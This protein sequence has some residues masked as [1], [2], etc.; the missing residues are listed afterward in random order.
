MWGGYARF[1]VILYMGAIVA[2]QFNSVIRV[3]YQRLQRVRKARE[4][5]L[6]ACMRR[7]LTI[8]NVM[9]NHRPC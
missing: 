6:T 5:A 1:R 4:V 9:L 3:F 7:L 8:L 2:P